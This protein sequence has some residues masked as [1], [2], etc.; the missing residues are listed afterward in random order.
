[1]VR[2]MGVW[3]PI[4]RVD[5]RDEAVVFEFVWYQRRDGDVNQ[6]VQKIAWVQ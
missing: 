3:F 6:A 5:S 4:L 2:S 1:M